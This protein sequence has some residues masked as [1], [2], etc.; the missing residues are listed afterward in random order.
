MDTKK[1]GKECPLFRQIDPE[2]LTA[3]LKCLSAREV[4]AEKGEFIE[5]T[6]GGK[7][8]MG[9]V[10]EGAVEMISEDYFGKKSILTVLTV[11]QLFG[12]TY[13]CLQARNRTV[14]F[15]VRDTCRVLILDY[16]RIL[17]ACKLVCRFHHRMIENMVELIAEKNLEL[18]EKLEVSS[19][20]SIREKL[21]TYLTRQAER[22]GSLTFTIPLG[23]TELAEYLCTDRSAMTRELSKLRSEGII[24]FDKRTFTLKEPWN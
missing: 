17:H 8:L 12:E 19:R 20:T 1:L 10:L 9:V 22:T 3:L 16:D 5:T 23:R 6:S 24:D 11:G 2:D 7:P 18:I 14:A 4:T 21:L 13:S 15:Q